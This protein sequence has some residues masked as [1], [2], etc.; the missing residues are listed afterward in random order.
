MCY[1]IRY[2]QG[3]RWAEPAPW[4][5][6]TGAFALCVSFL[7]SWRLDVRERMLAASDGQEAKLGQLKARETADCQGLIESSGG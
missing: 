3:R 4:G 2:L 1:D 6:A 7:C 5:G